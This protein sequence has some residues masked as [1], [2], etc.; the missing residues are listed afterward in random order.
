VIVHDGELDNVLESLQ[1]KL[2]C[3]LGMI[4]IEGRK[5]R[6]LGGSKDS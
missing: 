3:L 1:S 5:E 2:G 4:I 6:A